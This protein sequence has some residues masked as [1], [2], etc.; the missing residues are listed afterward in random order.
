MIKFLQHV[1]G[2]TFSPDTVGVATVVIND[3]WQSPKAKKADVSAL[4]AM[5]PRARSLLN[6]LLRRPRSASAISVRLRESA[7]W[8]V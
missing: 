1:R 6:T 7:T 4:H 5:K 3:A 2:W 8:P